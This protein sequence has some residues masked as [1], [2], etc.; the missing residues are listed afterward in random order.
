MAKYT[1]NKNKK[2]ITKKNDNVKKIQETEGGNFGN[3]QESTGGGTPFEKG[4]SNTRTTRENGKKREAQNPTTSQPRDSMGHFTYKSVNGKSIDPKYG[5]SRGKTVNP[6]LT[7]GDGTIKIEDVEKQ[8]GAQSGVYWDKYKDKWY[9]KGGKVVTAGL[10]TKVSAE[11][12]WEMAKKRYDT[13][14]GEFEGESKN[15]ST[16]TGKKSAAEKA[17]IQKAKSTGEQQF[18]IDSSTGAIETKGGMKKALK[19]FAEKKKAPVVEEKV[20]EKVEEQPAQNE[21]PVAENPEDKKPWGS[22]KYNIGQK[23]KALNKIKA[24]LGD[25][26]DAEI[27]EDESTLEEFIDSQPTILD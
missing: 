27:W 16:K 11:T 19:D 15:W 20:E 5:P 4:N 14:K 21:Q 18:A 13:V 1:P 2:S 12:I 3:Y 23:N 25:E 7:G 17:A 8:F 22:G 10:S 6:L 9:Q 26:Y 24:E